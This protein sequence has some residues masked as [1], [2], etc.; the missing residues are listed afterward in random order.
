MFNSIVISCIFFLLLI[1][2]KIA[3]QLQ[4]LIEWKKKVEQEQQE[5][6]EKAKE[7]LNVF[8]SLSEKEMA[9]IKFIF[10]RPTKSA[11]FPLYSEIALLLHKQYIEVIAHK[12][13]YNENFSLDKSTKDKLYKISETA[14]SLIEQNKE[15]IQISW[16]KI[17]INKKWINYQD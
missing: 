4:S 8:L 9:I 15:E 11:W 3:F 2:C 17:H 1:V 5:Q 14:L 10:T 16:K 7:K 12:R 6:T 13:D